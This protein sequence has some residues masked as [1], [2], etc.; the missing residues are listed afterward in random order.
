MKSWLV[1]WVCAL[2]GAMA[3]ACISAVIYFVMCKYPVVN[4][5]FN[6]VFGGNGE[7]VEPKQALISIAV[8][9]AIVLCAI[10]IALCFEKDGDSK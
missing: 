7:I 2:V 9:T 6:R 1:K 5:A 8:F 10:R 4:D 3:F